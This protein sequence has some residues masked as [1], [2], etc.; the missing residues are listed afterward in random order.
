[1]TPATAMIVT[2]YG[3]AWNSVAPDSENAGRR[4]ASALQKPNRH[5][6]ASAPPGR[7]RPQI[8]TASA[9]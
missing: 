1:M 3:S 2:T 7:Q 6:N 9:M 5:A 4:W 8:T